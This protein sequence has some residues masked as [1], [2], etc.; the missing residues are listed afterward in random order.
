LSL[1]TLI[2]IQQGGEFYCYG[3]AYRMMFGTDERSLVGR[4]TGIIE[5]GINENTGLEN[6]VPTMAM[7]KQYSDILGNEIATDHIL[8]ASN[9]KLREVAITYDF[10]TH[11]LR[12]TFIQSA[13]LSAIGRN[14]FFFYNAAGD[15]DPEASY[16]S[17]PVGTAFEHSSLPST[18][19]YGLNLKLNF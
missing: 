8:D 7:L 2:S 18:R 4:E 13:S 9:V 15:I 3:R 5:T 6:T 19:S 12:N 1:N 11:M 16:N 14:L 10:P 17:G